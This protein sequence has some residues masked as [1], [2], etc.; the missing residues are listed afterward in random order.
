MNKFEPALQFTKNIGHCDWTLVQELDQRLVPA[1][2]LAKTKKGAETNAFPRPGLN[3][4]PNASIQPSA[5]HY[6]VST[7]PVQFIK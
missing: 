6:Y 7:N 5:V 1:V 3:S 2:A 4:V